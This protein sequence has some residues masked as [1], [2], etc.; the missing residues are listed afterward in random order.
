MDNKLHGNGPK[1]SL[2]HWRGGRWV[3]LPHSLSWGAAGDL[4]VFLGG[5]SCSH[6]ISELIERGEGQLE[7]QGAGTI[8]SEG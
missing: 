5:T 4:A 6:L 7:E 2:H 1:P 8:I 3:E